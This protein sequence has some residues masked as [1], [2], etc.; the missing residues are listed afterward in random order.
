[1]ITEKER[2]KNEK[3]MSV[4]GGKNKCRKKKEKE[5]TS[6]TCNRAP[7]E[8]LTLYGCVSPGFSNF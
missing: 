6:V 3:E 7:Y 8:Y 4:K 1:M 2:E 5:E